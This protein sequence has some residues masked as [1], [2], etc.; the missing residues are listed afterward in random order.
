MRVGYSPGFGYITEPVPSS[1]AQTLTFGDDRV[2]ST[3]EGLEQFK[4]YRI[5]NDTVVHT[6]YL[7]LYANEPS[8]QPEQSF[9]RCTDLFLRFGEQY[10]NTLLPMVL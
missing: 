7:A 10:F 4:Y 6:P 3:V 5:L 2:S 8:G 1:P 9:V